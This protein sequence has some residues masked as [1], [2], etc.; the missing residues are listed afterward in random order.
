MPT[1]VSW[2][3]QSYSIPQTGEFNWQSLTD[4]LV[5]VG[6]N[7]QTV[8]FQKMAIRVATTS[9]VTVASATDCIVVSNLSVAGPVAVTLPPGV[10]KQIF[11]IVDGRG[12]AATNN[13]T[14]TPDGAETINGAATYVLNVNRGGIGIIYQTGQG[15]TV[16]AEFGNAT[17]ST[18]YIS[19]SKIAADVPA[20]GHVIINDGSGFLSSEAQLASTRG[21]TGVSNAGTL[22][23]GANN[24]TFTTSGATAIT[25]PLSGTLVTRTGAETL[26][27]KTL[28]TP[29]ING[30]SVDVDA[31]GALAIG[32]SV[33]ANNITLGGATSSTI[34]P[35][36]LTI[37]GTTTTV[38]TQTLDVKDKNVTVNKGGNDA[39]SEGAG[40]TIDRTGTKG[41]II[42]KDASASKFAV[43]ALGA[44]ADVVTTSESQTL[45]NKT[46]DASL[47]ISASAVS[48]P[49]GV[50][51]DSNTLVIDAANDRVGVGTA[52]PSSKLSVNG[53]FS[54]AQA[55]VSN[56]VGSSASLSINP[57]G[58]SA[59]TF[60]VASNAT[61]SGEQKNITIGATGA[62]G[63][64]TIVSFGSAI[65]GALNRYT[66]NGKQSVQLPAGNNT[67]DRPAIPADGMIRYNSTDNTYEG[68]STAGG[69]WAAIGGGGA[70]STVTTGSPHG[71]TVGDILYLNGSTYTKAIATSA[72]A[73]EVVGIVSKNISLTSFELT[74]SGL[75]TGILSPASLTAGSV[76]FLSDATAALMTTT[77]PTTIGNVSVPLGVAVTSTSIY[78]APKRGA[79][80]G[81]ANARTQITLANNATTTIQGVS[82][83]DAGSI[84]GWV[85][86]DAT[87]D[88]KFYFR[89]P[90]AK[91]GAGTDYNISPSYVGDTPPA[92][93]SMTVTSG[94]NIQV[95]LPSV[96]GFVSA[97]ANFALNAPA[98][99]TNFPLAIDGSQIT[100]GTVGASYLPLATSTTRGA[101]SYYDEGTWTATVTN[102]GNLSG[103]GTANTLT[104]TRIGNVVFCRIS[105]IT[106]LTTTTAGAA[107]TITLTPSG[108]PG[109][110]NT[111]QYYGSGRC[112]SG[113]NS[114]VAGITDNSGT[115]T[116]INM[117]W[118]AQGSAIAL[119]IN[120]ISF[121]Y[122]I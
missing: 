87:T 81:G 73:A 96:A 17:G 59:A 89:A 90:F 37:Q 67:T 86:I 93:F 107:T 99:G 118:N 12:D 29:L 83:Y 72:T 21:G 55:N 26:E 2:N 44:E 7:A 3:G 122:T 92:G 10:D 109:I 38:D 76:Y 60:S 116:L 100:G 43:G 79:V 111:T 30:G 84:E 41:S 61:V 94:G 51:F 13:L 45:T 8:N 28:K 57:L 14:I 71:F 5:A 19:R 112:D 18:S 77:E 121:T 32:A 80:V 75:V 15:W 102:A 49:N 97:V 69:G 25:L 108:L 53:D 105:S 6:N 4:F 47:T 48:T 63:S 66:F 1:S 91:N 35:G 58:T 40:L 31:A 95:T 24:I 104:Y 88:Y 78:F 42:Y 120:S 65:A 11:F 119:T 113:G 46:L 82:T 20:A 34:I 85:Y 117:N 9:P 54:C 27:D 23:Y 101:I 36:N 106:G 56:I 110:T 98:V 68:Y 70:K 62:S 114:I 22:T 39:T 64:E 16:F 115:T 103:T 33:G 50:N 74:L 52:T